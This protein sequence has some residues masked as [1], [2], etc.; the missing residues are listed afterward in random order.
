MILLLQKNNSVTQVP[1]PFSP[2]KKRHSPLL[3]PLLRGGR[4]C[5]KLF[6]DK[7]YYSHPAK[8]TRNVRVQHAEPLRKMEIINKLSLEHVVAIPCSNRL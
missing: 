6:Q 8:K 5:V 1:K 4:R 7:T 3:I 2:S